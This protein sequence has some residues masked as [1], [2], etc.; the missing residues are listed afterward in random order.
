MK[1]KDPSRIQEPRTA[2][3]T[4]IEYR[5]NMVVYFENSVGNNIEKLQNFA[6]Y[7]PRQT[8]SKFISRYELFKKI[9]NVQGSIIECGV[10][11]GGGL[12]TFAQLSAI[13]EPVN[14]QRKIIGFDTFSGFAGL[15]KED[16]KGKSVHSRN[17]ALAIDSYE[18]LKKCIELYDANR[19][20]CHIPKVLLVKGDIQVTLPKY[21][22]DN[23]QTVVS[24]LYIDVDVFGPTKVAIEH[25][26]PRMP[27]GAIIV[28]DELN[29][30]SWPGET[31]AVLKTIGIRNLSIQRFSFDSW[32][33]FAVI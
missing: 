3:E 22:E 7:V 19:F 27:K 33:S 12:M 13:F 29:S 20:I 32:V 21:L 23:P 31:I 5:N 14:S 24:L 26:V 17:G 15:S 25:L 9:L 10:Y 4:E 8:L 1:T 30:E 11:L 2:S 18:D 28:F 6:K 16:E